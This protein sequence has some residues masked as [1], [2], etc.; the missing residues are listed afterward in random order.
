[1]GTPDF[2]VPSLKALLAGS[3]T[4]VCVVTAPDKP[5]GRGMALQSSAVKKA[6]LQ[7]RLPVLQPIQL[8]DTFFIQQLR[9]F[10][11]DLF[12]VVAFRI[13]PPDVFTVPPNGTVNLHAS[14]LP[15]YRGA[16]PI[17]WAII[18][19]EQETGVT[20][21]FIEEKV[22][23]GIVIMQRRIAIGADMNG[24]ELHD[25][26][27]TIGAQVLCQTVDCIAAGSCVPVK[28]TGEVTLA[29]KITKELCSVH[30]NKSA[31]EIHNLIRALSPQPGAVSTLHGKSH[32]ILASRLSDKPGSAE[33]GTVVDVS[34]NAGIEVQTGRGVISLLKI[35]PEG[36]RI[37][38]CEEYVRGHPLRRGDK[39][40]T[41]LS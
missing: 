23:T 3:H 38:T 39:F 2:A 22:D 13:L 29:P 26:L 17:Q 19:G 28:Q 12:V 35:Q 10:Q 5:A 31:V 20:T 18:N 34:R 1:M 11:P 36:R 6:A 41:R 8:R 33:P 25:I 7:A 4:V 9:S 40:I 16:A 21:F 32:K 14:L 15:R 27:A 30:W 24:G 37:M